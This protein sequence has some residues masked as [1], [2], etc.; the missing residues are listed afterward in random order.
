MNRLQVTNL[1]RHRFPMGEATDLIVVKGQ[2]RDGWV[3]VA[4][5]NGGGTSITNGSEYYWPL[6]L[7]ELNLTGKVTLVEGYLSGDRAESLDEVLFD[8]N[9]SHQGWRPLSEDRADEVAGIL[10]QSGIQPVTRVI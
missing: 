1:I 6:I 8:A 7:G 9:G 2:A 4:L 10:T 3:V 5:D